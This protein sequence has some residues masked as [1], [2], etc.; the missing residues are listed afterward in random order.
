MLGEEI[1]LF[2]IN[3]IK[4]K[5][6]KAIKPEKKEDSIKIITKSKS[7]RIQQI[8]VFGVTLK[9]DNVRGTLG[10]PSNCFSFEFEN[11]FVKF[12]CKGNGHGVGMSQNGANILA[13][14]KGYNYEQIIKHYYPGVEIK[15][16]H[17]LN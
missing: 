7:N 3:K 8:E 17:D 14:E 16:I 5:N 15:N 10:L 13:K 6:E 2:P 4:S 1:K 11:D 12:K 9:Y